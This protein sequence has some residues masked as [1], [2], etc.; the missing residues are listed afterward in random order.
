M[1]GNR[2]TL[3]VEDDGPGIAPETANIS[4][5]LLFAS[6]PAGIAQPRLRVGVGNCPLYSTG[7]GRYVNCDTSELGGARFSFSWPLWITSRNLPLPDTT[8]TV[9][10]SPPCAIK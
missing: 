6:I 3:I 9:V 2:A 7:N 4:L 5:N 10:K 1:S 8:R